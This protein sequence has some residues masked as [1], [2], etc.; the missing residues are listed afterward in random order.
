MSSKNATYESFIKKSY[1]NTIQFDHYKNGKKDQKSPSAKRLTSLSIGLRSTAFQV[2]NKNNQEETPSAQPQP[3]IIHKS[4]VDEPA[5]ETAGQYVNER[6]QIIFGDFMENENL[7]RKLI[8]KTQNNMYKQYE[9][10]S[11]F[12][13]NNDIYNKMLTLKETISNYCLIIH[14]YLKKNQYMKALELFLLMCKKNKMIIDYFSTKINYHLPRM[15]KSN[16]IA[17]Y[18]PLITRLFM[19]VLS[20]LIKLSSKFCKTILENYF[21]RK[22]L[23][24]I[25]IVSDTVKIKFGDISNVVGMENYIKHI[26]NYFYANCIFD[27]SIYYF[28]KYQP[29][30]L[31]NFILQHILD[32]YK[33]DSFNDLLDVEQV[34]LLKVN[35][36]LGLFLYADGCN[37]EAINNLNQ[38]KKRLFD[39]NELPLTKEANNNNKAHNTNQNDNSNDFI[40]A[41]ILSKLTYNNKRFGS[42]LN[43]KEKRSS[44]KYFLNKTNN[45]NMK[46]I[47]HKNTQKDLNDNHFNCNRSLLR[48]SGSSFMEKTLNKYSGSQQKN[49]GLITSETESRASLPR[50]SSGVLFGFQIMT[51][52]Q[53]CEN[54]EE[55]IYNEIELILG[56]IELSQKN[57]P[58]ALKHLKKLLKNH[59]RSKPFI[60]DKKKDSDDHSKISKKE[61]TESN[62][63]NFNL[64]ADSDKKKIMGLLDKIDQEYDRNN[65]C[66]DNSIDI[67]I[68]KRSTHFY[69]IRNNTNLDGKKLI[70]SKEMEKFFIFILDLSVYQ[71][72][73]LN[74]TQPK[75]SK[76]RNDLPIIFNNQFKDCLTNSQR[77]YLSRLESMNLSRYI[78]LNDV[79][80]DICPENLDFRF[81]KYRIK[82]TDSDDEKEFNKYQCTKIK[83]RKYTDNHKT[84][85]ETNNS[86]KYNNVRSS[87]K[88]LKSDLERKTF[89]TNDLETLLSYIKNKEI[90][91][92][93]DSYKNDILKLLNNLKKEEQNEIRNSPN[94]F[95]EFIKALR[96]GVIQK[97]QKEKE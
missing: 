69:I 66:N 81:M 39:I 33:N 77:M 84:Q 24:I 89:S 21:T 91:E 35:Y 72:K 43:D 23:E 34:L 4:N 88:K 78:I 20:C 26:G 18:F 44:K 62:N 19:Q 42:F 48:M 87:Y 14:I 79:N 51:L 57:Y 68:P 61:G 22:Y 49:K 96:V 47:F 94:K 74:E 76:K 93:I 73:I 3:Q 95:K 65:N 32:L 83:E 30:I 59:K 7:V 75:P 41:P 6:K 45:D 29:L 92:F 71:L 97:E 11:F 55:K 80:G 40:S 56:E 13:P 8:I 52:Q 86:Y 9:K 37:I 28:I 1:T 17:K 90:K 53:Q 64:L 67:E 50:K 82:D 36:N 85:D 10:N 70:N 38:A 58:E 2:E 46:K 25:N 15:T 54:V 60:R 31:C 12:N 63:C 5:P 27:T 16:R